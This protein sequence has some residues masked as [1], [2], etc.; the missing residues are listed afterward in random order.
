[1]TGSIE[2]V[3]RGIFQKHLGQRI[4][5]GIVLAARKEGKIGISFGRYGDSPERN[6]IPA[7]SFAVVADTE[8]ELQLHLS[9][10]E[11]RHRESPNP[12]LASAAETESP[13][14]AGQGLCQ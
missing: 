6:G 13:S 11:V 7:K 12:A 4:T 2:V 10:Y 8:E 3:Y 14:A 9:R 1:M 5:R